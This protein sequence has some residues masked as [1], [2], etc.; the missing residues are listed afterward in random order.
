M[1]RCRLPL[2]GCRLCPGTPPP[3]GRRFPSGHSPSEA[4]G[5]PGWSL[6]EP[7]FPSGC[8]LHPSGRRVYLSGRRVYPGTPPPPGRRFLTGR[9]PRRGRRC[10]RKPPRWDLPW[11][12]APERP[13]NRWPDHPLS[14]RQPPNRRLPSR[15]LQSPA[16]P[17][18]PSESPPRSPGRTAGRRRAPAPAGTCIFFSVNSFS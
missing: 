2:S 14:V 6:P 4:P 8:R 18:G 10:S 17:A 5:P 13:L 16:E 3:P 15:R 7:S 1:R 12:S 9:S 11:K